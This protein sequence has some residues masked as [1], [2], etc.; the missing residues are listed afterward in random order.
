[1]AVYLINMVA[2]FQYI[3]EKTEK[4]GHYIEAS[5]NGNM[6]KRKILGTKVK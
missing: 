6:T 5:R 1:M 3:K 2:H 4:N